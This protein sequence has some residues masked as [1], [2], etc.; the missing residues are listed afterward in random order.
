MGFWSD[1]VQMLISRMIQREIDE[2]ARA[3]VRHGEW[4]HDVTIP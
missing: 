1:D 3:M 4:H 2:A